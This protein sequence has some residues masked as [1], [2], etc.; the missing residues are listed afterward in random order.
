[1]LN[2]SLYIFAS[3][4][5]GYAIRIVLPIFLVRILVQAD[6]GAYRQFFLLEQIVAIL[7]Q[8]GINQSLFY[9]IPRD[10]AN[11]GAYFVNSLAMNVLV[12][13]VAFAVIT[14]VRGPLAAALNMVALASHYPQ[15]VCYTVILML[16]TA[17]DCYL[18]A[19]Q[20]ILPSAVFEVVGQ[21]GVSGATLVVAALTRD[22]GQI[23]TTL[24]VARLA[25]FLAMVLYVHLRL[26]G[27]RARRYFHGLRAQLGYGVVLGLGGAAWSLLLRVHP[28]VVSRYL[29][30]EA[31]AVYSNGITELPI[32]AYYL[33]ALTVVSLGQFAVLEQQDDWDGIRKLWREILTGMYGVVVPFVILLIVIARPLVLAMFTEQYAAAVPIFRI[34]A[35]AMFSLLWNAQ[36]V[37]RAMRRNDVNLYIYGGLLLIS[38]F[39]LL[40]CLH[41]G[42]MAGVITGQVLLM[43]GGRLVCLAILNRLGDA[44]LPYVVAPREVLAF[45]RESWLKGRQ[46]VRDWRRLRAAPG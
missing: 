39:V 44:R 12:Y 5:A 33:Q 35:L 45:Y 41:L 38:P 4:M 17:T 15:L 3:K 42:G 20:R 26:H 40:G 36:L 23:F 28:V 18:C 31:F 43:L 6:Y 16:I 7:F 22:I 27:L 1:M 10:E 8:F 11:A 24:V 2:R 13:S 19:R 32:V 29:G 37:L 21:L 46:K 9:F 34:N 25:H 30:V 14:P